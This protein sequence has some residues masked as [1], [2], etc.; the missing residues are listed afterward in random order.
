MQQMADAKHT[1][2]TLHRL[3]TQQLPTDNRRRLQRDGQSKISSGG[4]FG[5]LKNR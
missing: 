5:W 1:D 2:A 3:G 4:I